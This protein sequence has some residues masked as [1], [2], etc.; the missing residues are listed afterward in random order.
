MRETKTTKYV[1]STA[2]LTCRLWSSTASTPTRPRSPVHSQTQVSRFL[3][4]SI[5]VLILLLPLLT[6]PLLSQRIIASENG[7][8]ST[9]TNLKAARTSLPRSPCLHSKIHSHCIISQHSDGPETEVARIHISRKLSSSIFLSF[10]IMTTDILYS[11]FK[12][13]TL[14]ITTEWRNKSAPDSWPEQANDEQ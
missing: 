11:G 4:C 7:T 8:T 13:S 6:I 14:Y 12:G 5:L 9:M 3:H 10:V 2:K 1:S